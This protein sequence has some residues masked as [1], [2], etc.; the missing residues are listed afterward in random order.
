MYKRLKA[1]AVLAA[2]VLIGQMVVAGSAN[3]DS[4]ES[5]GH[6][7]IGLQARVAD[8]VPG[9]TKENTDALVNCFNSQGEMIEFAT[10]GRISRT[11]I[12]HGRLASLAEL[13]PD[14]SEAGNPLLG[15][16]YDYTNFEGSSLIFYG[17]NGSGCYG[18]VTY[19]WR[20]VG[21]AWNDEFSSGQSFSN[22][23]HEVYEH[24]GYDGARSGTATLFYSYGLL[25][26]QVTSVVFR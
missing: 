21:P 1:F 26:E 2:F 6:C 13:S 23:G 16:L 15:I 14:F 10:G 20:N 18:G 8:Y 19:G 12:E 17:E 9:I 22:C 25:N 7:A 5:K 4:K 24:A 3:A 11:E